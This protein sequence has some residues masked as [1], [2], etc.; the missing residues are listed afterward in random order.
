[1][2]PRISMAETSRMLKKAGIKDDEFW[3]EVLASQ[4]PE[5]AIRIC[6]KWQE[7]AE[8]VTA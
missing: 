4:S 3:N 8:E 2:D 1:M 7:K 5:D 6:W